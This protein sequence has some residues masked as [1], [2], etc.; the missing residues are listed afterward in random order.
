MNCNLHYLTVFFCVVAQSM[1]AVVPLLRPVALQGDASPSAG[2]ASN[3]WPLAAGYL[4][5]MVQEAGRRIQRAPYYPEILQVYDQKLF[6]RLA[7]S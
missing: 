1:D 4:R 6:G 7:S 2:G 3:A 5:R